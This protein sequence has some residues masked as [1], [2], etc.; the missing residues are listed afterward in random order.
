MAIPSNWELVSWDV[1]EE[2]IPDPANPLALKKRKHAVAVRKRVSDTGSS[3]ESVGD[4]ANDLT[5][6]VGSEPVVAP[7]GT[8]TDWYLVDKS[9]RPAR[10]MIYIVV[11]QRWESWGEWQTFVPA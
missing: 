8:T 4:T 5:F 10:P 9:I 2:V 6:Y 7:S 1:S 11:E 3:S